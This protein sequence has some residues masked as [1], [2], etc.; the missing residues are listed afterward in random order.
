MNQS[1]PDYGDLK[2]KT[3]HWAGFEF[4]TTIGAVDIQVD[5]DSELKRELIESIQNTLK[6]ID[7]IDRKARSYLLEKTNG[8][9]EGITLIEPSLLFVPDSAIGS[10]TLFYSNENEEDETCY[11]VEFR[12]NEPLDISIG[13]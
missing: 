11:G 10:F 7:I 1:I 2:F 12:D 8:E 9:L 13:D 4:G 6:R 5:S 3:D